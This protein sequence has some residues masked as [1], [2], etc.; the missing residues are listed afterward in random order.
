MT[1]NQD[2]SPFMPGPLSE[3]Q[4]QERLEGCYESINDSAEA[5]EDMIACRMGSCREE[6]KIKELIKEIVRLANQA[7]YNQRKLED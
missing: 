6:R 2:G 4:I 5:F 7:C 3:K 1:H